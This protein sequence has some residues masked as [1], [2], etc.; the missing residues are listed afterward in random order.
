MSR[1]TPDWRMAN[2]CA[3]CTYTLDDEP[4]LKYSKLFTCDGNDSLKRVANASVVDPR[5]L[6]NDYFLDSKF[7][8]RFANEVPRRSTKTAKTALA[9]QAADPQPGDNDERDNQDNDDCEAEAL[10]CHGCW[11]NS[12]ADEQGK[13][14]VV[15]DETGVFVVSCRHGHII[16]VEDMRQS[17]ELSKYGLAVVHKLC[18]VFGDD[19]L[20]GY[21]IGCTFRTTALR[22]PLVG[23]L[24]TKHNMKFVTG[25]FHG[26]AHNRKC[27]VSNHPINTVGAGLEAFKENEQLFSSTNNVAR[28]TRHSSAFHRRQLLALHLSGWD[29]GRRCAIG[30]ILKS[31]YMS[32]L[33]GQSTW[34]KELIRLAPDKTNDDLRAMHEEERSYFA[35]LKVPNQESSFAMHYLKRLRVLA[36]KQQAWN[37]AFEANMAS[38]TPNMIDTY[39]NHPTITGTNKEHQYQH[40]FASQVRKLEA[41][42]T[43]T[44]EQLIVIQTE[45]ARLE[46]EHDI[47]PRWVPGCVEWEEAAKRE[48][49]E[50]YHQALRELELLVV[51]RII[52]FDKSQAAGTG[53]KGRVHM[54]K[55]IK[56]REKAVNNAL[57][58]YNAAARAV[59]PPRPTITFPEITEY[60]YQAN[61]DFLKYSEHG[62]QNAEW[63]RPVN[64]RCVELWQKLERAKE[65]VIRLNVEIRRVYT[66]IR[67][68]DRFLAL[69]YDRL[70]SSDPNLAHILYTRIQLT[71][72]VNQVIK[73]DLEAIS[74][75]KG[76]TGDLTFGVRAGT[77]GCES[78]ESP[79]ASH[80]FVPQADTTAGAS[81]DKADD[82][83]DDVI[84]VEPSDEAQH[85]MMAIETCRLQ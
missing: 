3:A 1:D 53:Y 34:A 30:S 12:Q 76:F 39:R 84:E 17:G 10:T 21:D 67:D 37:E 47:S 74:K 70:K 43:A 46:A 56:R 62:D 35:S 25:S 33:R 27:Q 13:K 22:S 85:T 44:S 28:T 8:D 66:H 9:P 5:V 54:A 59:D 48:K 58:R 69:Q 77:F 55:G 64:R 61:F 45:V 52:E 7:V 57:N 49:L 80:E 16:L 38:I 63:R 29:F 24:V 81:G 26:Y 79:A 2:A 23:P 11:K 20:L 41:R 83:L 65:E 18:S 68:E 42:R 75:L 60:A 31:R 19:I 82:V 72:R 6:E 4:K 78:S 73:Q 40:N 71:L 50:D 51:Q 15:F 14:L 32:A 36:E